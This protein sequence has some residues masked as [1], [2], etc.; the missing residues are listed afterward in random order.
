MRCR[1]GVPGR[2]LACCP[3]R[4]PIVR[5]GAPCVQGGQAPRAAISH[6]E[7]GAR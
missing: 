5:I 3:V 7:A 4:D 1:P 2:G 6:I